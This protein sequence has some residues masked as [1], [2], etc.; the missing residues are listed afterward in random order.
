MGDPMPDSALKVWIGSDAS[1]ALR[2][3]FCRSASKKHMAWYR[4]SYIWKQPFA[5]AN[6][7]WDHALTSD[8]PSLASTIAVVPVLR[9]NTLHELK[10]R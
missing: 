3:C 4:W 6:P 8:Y 10:T 7:A 1:Y 9:R 5:L 2:S